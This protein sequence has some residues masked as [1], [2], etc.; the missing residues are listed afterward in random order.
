M[1][2]EAWTVASPEPSG[3]TSAFAS[4]PKTATPSPPPSAF[5]FA[6]VSAVAK[7]EMPR[8]APEVTAPSRRD[9]TVPLKIALLVEPPIAAKP[10][11]V[12]P[13]VV[14]FSTENCDERRPMPVPARTPLPIDP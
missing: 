2:S 3:S 10:P 14:A 1:P 12:R 5:A 7:A 13:S 9:L 8:L 4:A 11:I 6:V